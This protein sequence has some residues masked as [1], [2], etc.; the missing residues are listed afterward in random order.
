MHP[1]HCDD[2]DES[3]SGTHDSRQAP[4]T[5]A[6]AYCCS[7]STTHNR[8]DLNK[9]NTKKRNEETEQKKKKKKKKKEVEEDLFLSPS[10]PL[11][12]QQLTSCLLTFWW[13][14]A[15]GRQAHRKKGKK[16]PNANL[17]HQR[18][19]LSLSL[20]VCARKN[21]EDD[22]GKHGPQKTRLFSFFTFEAPPYTILVQIHPR[23]CTPREFIYTYIYN[24]QNTWH[25]YILTYTYNINT[26]G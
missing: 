8:R 24:I 20:S 26:Y 12:Q 6:D 22:N 17:T 4:Q 25:V 23:I 5:T 3:T 21:T 18:K 11:Q 9:K 1:L 14:T 15:A 13:S 16:K 19:S 7:Q 10:S 2:N